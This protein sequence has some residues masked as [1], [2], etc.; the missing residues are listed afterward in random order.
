[1]FVISG[2]VIGIL[3]TVLLVIVIGLIGF[4]ISRAQGAS[5]MKNVFDQI[6]RGEMPTDTLFDGLCIIVGSILLV[7]PGF[8]SDF[9]ALLFLIPFTRKYLKPIIFRFISRRKRVR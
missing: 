7:I 5:L 2:H 6:R 8:V 9:L 4:I 1:M 3:Y